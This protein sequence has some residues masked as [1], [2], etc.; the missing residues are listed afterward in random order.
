[1]PSDN[2][3]A[4]EIRP[5]VI[6]RQNSQ[7][8]RSGNGANVQAILMSVYRTFK[9]RGLDLL[10]TTVSALKTYVVTGSLPPLPEAK[11]SV[12]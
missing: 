6:M 12:D 5:A 9:L 4:R 8:N 7:G 3:A 2:H 10:D 1:M 11:L